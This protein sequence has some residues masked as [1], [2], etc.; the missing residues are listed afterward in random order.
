MAE[1]LLKRII[2]RLG[3]EQVEIRSAGV[4]AAASNR[5]AT[6]EAVEVLAEIGLDLSEHRNRQLTFGLVGWADAVLC[7]ETE[8]LYGVADFLD[9]PCDKNFLLGQWLPPGTPPEIEDPTGGP[10]EGFRE[11][12]DRIHRSLERF[13]EEVLR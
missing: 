13:A 2:E 9:P 10:M 8:H 7:M 3:I 12:R 5:P 4:F 1:F 6:P 11:C